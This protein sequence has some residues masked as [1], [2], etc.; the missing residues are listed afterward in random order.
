MKK[1]GFLFNG[2]IIDTYD[3]VYVLLDKAEYNLQALS[4]RFNIKVENF[5]RA[6][7]D[8]SA[9]LSIFIELL[10]I[11]ANLGL[12]NTKFKNININEENGIKFAPKYLSYCIKESKLSN[13]DQKIS[14]KNNIKKS[15]KQNIEFPKTC[16]FFF[17]SD[18]IGKYIKNYEKRSNQVQMSQFIERNLIKS[19]I[20]LVEATP[21]T[22][23]TLGY[24]VPIVIDILK[25]KS[26]A[27]IATNTIALQD[28]IINKDWSLIKNYLEDSGNLDNVNLS[29]LKGRKNYV[30]K[31]I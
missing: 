24:L 2:A 21:G 11:Q 20:N 17:S 1:N 26:K 27:V 29:I 10:K 25:N 5:H 30:C 15:L 7:D 28:Q 16:E 4:N 18:G 8:S 6:K 13:F 12:I 23:K 14:S 9:T 31:E 19:K 22:G 3:L